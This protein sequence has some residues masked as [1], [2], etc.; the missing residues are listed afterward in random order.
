MH[1]NFQLVKKSNNFFNL[2][3]LLLA[4]TSLT[5]CA[6]LRPKASM[7][8]VYPPI[9]PK[10]YQSEPPEIL[11][12]ENSFTELED[13]KTFSENIE[14]GRIDPFL[15]P[16]FKKEKLIIPDTFKFNGVIK[17]NNQVIALVSNNGSDGALSVGDLGGED[18]DLIPEG[19]IVNKIS[20]DIPRLHLKYL[21]KGLII[22]LR[23]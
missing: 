7:E 15:P 18:T 12:S 1:K 21:N 5:S 4:Y 2:F 6:A 16:M 13:S 20:N 10:E 22:D 23:E 17:I 9:I 11:D 8:M 14:V 3:L 19:W